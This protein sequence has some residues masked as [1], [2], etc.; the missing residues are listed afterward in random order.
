VSSEILSLKK[1]PYVALAVLTA[2]GF[3][4]FIVTLT[5]GRL[6]PLQAETRRYLYAPRGWKDRKAWMAEARELQPTGEKLELVGSIASAGGG[7]TR[8]I[9]LDIKVYHAKVGD[10]LSGIALRFALDL[11]T[12]ASLNREWGS[13]VHHVSVGEE[14]LIPN[15]DGIFIRL[16]DDRS[17][18]TLCAE[19][20]V[21]AEVVLQVN[22]LDHEQVKP[23][24]DLFFPGVQHTGV[25]RSVA[26]G[27]AFLRPI[28][29]WQ[30][31]GFGY[32]R[33]PFSG[34]HAFHRGVDLAAPI[35]TPVRATLDGTVISAGEDPILGNCIVIRHQIGYT[36]VYGHLH[37]ILVRRGDLARRGQKIGTVGN[38]G[39]STGSHLHFEL[40][41]WG[42]PI[43]S[44]RLLL[45]M[46]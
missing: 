41:R 4:G 44:S 7:S 32:R 6:M 13:G 1:L 46:H 43:N 11:D 34:M 3:F 33:D 15:Q 27:A 26:V 5:A 22:G 21:P 42:V 24:T 8:P 36:S 14:L 12:I 17:L 9:P 18:E 37:R 10:T 25:E 38:T 16:Q 2:G 39:R 45:G 28:Q 31:S 23:G 35:G 30:S 29:G 40:R 20:E 19:K